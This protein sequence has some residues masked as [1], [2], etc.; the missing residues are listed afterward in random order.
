[1]T[2]LAWRQHRTEF[3]GLAILV[4]ALTIFVVGTGLPMRGFEGGLACLGQYAAPT[5][6]GQGDFNRAFGWL[7]GIVAWF[8]LIPLLIG[9]FIGGPLLGREFERGTH[10]LVWTQSVTRA[11][12]ITVKLATVALLS[13]AVGAA[14][15][16]LM[17][18]WRQPFD[19]VDS[20]F[21]GSGFDLEGLMP[22]AYVLFALGLGCAS[23]A[24]LR[25][26]LPAMAAT[27]P[28][29]LAVRLPVEFWLRP[30]YLPPITAIVSGSGAGAPAGAWVID[31]GLIDSAGHPV[32]A[33]QATQ[34]CGDPAIG[35]L[36]KSA[37]ACLHAHG[38][39]ERVVYQPLD[40]FWTFQY[41]EAGLYLAL[42]LALL[43]FT[44]FWVR[45][46]LR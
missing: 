31:N 10:R 7:A 28:A 18:W 9:I 41:I 30:H 39:F 12:W 6:G 37:D 15:A 27:L 33:A 23:G 5:C 26:V 36:L 35:A 29:F 2:W 43:A 22:G 45:R 24:L 46:R 20:P 44:V 40:R 8:N 34:L 16:G 14:I 21:T 17:T 13:I 25:K 42:S 32:Y 3:I 1:M 11:R 19:I 38:I 4:L